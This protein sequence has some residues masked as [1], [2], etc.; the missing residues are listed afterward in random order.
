[1]PNA[2][3]RVPCRLIVDPPADGAWNMAVDEALLESAAAS[4]RC[5]LRFYQWQQ[6]TL[7]LGYFQPHAARAAHYASRACALVRRQTGGGAILHDRELTYSL[8]IPRAHPLA[9]DSTRLYVVVHEAIQAV[10]QANHVSA[11]ICANPHKVAKSDEPFLC[12][13]RRAIGDMLLGG[14]KICGGAQRRRHGA[15]LQHGSLLFSQSAF[16]PELPG[17]LQLC[18]QPLT[19]AATSKAIVQELAGRH[20]FDFQPAQLLVDEFESARCLLSRKYANPTWTQWR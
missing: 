14:A 13:Q 4:G 3:V 20:G 17:I 1:M 2:P 6:P 9:V 12:F 16:A 5:S 18:G 10:L 11:T 8:V 7:S 19:P 15:V